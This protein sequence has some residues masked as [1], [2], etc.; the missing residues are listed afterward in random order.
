MQLG[1]LKLVPNRF[2]SRV[3]LV[4]FIQSK[5][6]ESNNGHEW[7]EMGLAIQISSS[8]VTE[9][10]LAIVQKNP[11]SWRSFNILFFRLH[12]TPFVRKNTPFRSR[13]IGHR[14]IRFNTSCYCYLQRSLDPLSFPNSTFLKT[15]RWK[16]SYLRIHVLSYPWFL[17][18]LLWRRVYIN[19]SE[20]H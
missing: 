18:F 13:C 1:N 6:I 3:R 10:V 17:C 2:V 19:W 14:P 16:C 4:S 9:V 8:R 5:S 12:F 20:S 7:K 11:W 15:L